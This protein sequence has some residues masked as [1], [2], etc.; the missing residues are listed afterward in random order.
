LAVT[1]TTTT[2]P[3]VFQLWADGQQEAV[4]DNDTINHSFSGATAKMVAI[5]PAGNN[6]SDLIG[7]FDLRAK[8]CIKTIPASI[9]RLT[10]IFNLD[11]G[12]NDFEAIIPPEIFDITG[13]E[14]LYLDRNANLTG[15]IPTTI[16]QVSATLKRLRIEFSGL[17]QVLPA[18]LY[19]CVNLISVQ[20]QG[21]SIPGTLSAS[22]GNLTKCSLFFA[23]S[24][25]ITGAVPSGIGGMVALVA[26]WLNY[27]LL[28][29]LESGIS[30]C[31]ALEQLL[32]DNNVIDTYELGAL[33]T[34]PNL[35][36]I[37]LQNNNLNQAGVDAVLADLVTSLSV[38]GRVT[39]AVQL[40]GN[41]PPSAS[42]L[43]DVNTLVSAGWTVS[44]D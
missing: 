38:T 40:Q 32:L 6:W 9:G 41:T 13:L 26:L 36:V 14:W 12:D 33:A 27:N 44:H 7:T 29:S 43:T 25:L 18:E 30:A 28:S 11:L 35:N 4:Y 17:N 21:N 31:L 42:G 34:Q 23:S 22:M 24:N 39:A 10:G 20:L 3:T 15:G 19:D 37:R 8:Q 1:V 2:G 16:S 5:T